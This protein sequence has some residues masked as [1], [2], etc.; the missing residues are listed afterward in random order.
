MRRP[1]AAHDGSDW[2]SILFVVGMVVGNRVTS[3]DL[4]RSPTLAG[5]REASTTAS[6]RREARLHAGWLLG[7]DAGRVYADDQ[8]RREAWSARRS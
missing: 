7:A 5:A 2:V 8:V 1:P 4:A 3:R 6:A